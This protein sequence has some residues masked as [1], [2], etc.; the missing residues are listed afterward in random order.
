MSSEFVTL[1]VGDK[2]FPYGTYDNLPVPKLLRCANWSPATDYCKGDVT[3]TCP[4]CLL[5][6]YCTMKCMLADS[7][8][9][10]VQCQ[11]DL[12]KE[13]W[14]A[15]YP[16]Y[17]HSTSDAAP[18]SGSNSDPAVFGPGDT[19]KSPPPSS[20]SSDTETTSG[21]ISD[22]P[23]FGPGDTPKSPPPSSSSSDTDTTSGNISDGDVPTAG[24]ASDAA[25]TSGRNAD[26]AV[27][28]AGSTPSS[29]PPA[30]SASD[31]T[32]ASGSTSGAVPMPRSEKGKFVTRRLWGRTPAVDMLN[33][34]MNEGSDF[35]GDLHLLLEDSAD[36]ASVFLT[37]SELPKTYT[38]SIEFTIN[39]RGDEIVFRNIIMLLLAF[40]VRK[41]EGTVLNKLMDLHAV[42]DCMIHIWYSP[43]LMKSHIDILQNFIKPLFDKVKAKLRIIRTNRPNVTTMVHVWNLKSTSIQATLSIEKWN[44]LFTFI[45]TPAGLTFEK[46]QHHFANPMKCVVTE[47]V[48]NH[49]FCRMPPTCRLALAK[50]YEDGMMLSFG[51]PRQLFTE[52]NPTFWHDADAPFQRGDGDPLDGWNPTEVFNIWSGPAINDIYG[53][54]W[55][56]LGSVLVR[57]FNRVKDLNVTFKVLNSRFEALPWAL[58][59]TKFD[60][61]DTSNIIDRGRRGAQATLGTLS[62]LLQP[63]NKNVHAVLMTRFENAVSA[64]LTPNN[65]KL[66]RP[67][68]SSANYNKLQSFFEG[69]FSKAIRFGDPE[70]IKILVTQRLVC[71]YDA[72]WERYAREE[73]LAQIGHECELQPKKKH[74]I[75]GEWPNAMKLPLG[76]SE[77]EKNLAGIEFHQLVAAGLSPMM[78]CV[79]WQKDENKW[80]PLAMWVL[81]SVL[82]CPRCGSIEHLTWE[83]CLRRGRRRRS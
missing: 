55:I 54:L 16:G 13:T 6:G 60:R 39:N 73:S 35:Q 2:M 4:K 61:I 14:R 19:P 28:A 5:P 33:L 67:P 3:T 81:N 44:K 76:R 52:P 24:G 21:N 25:A 29:P 79:E 62:G 36:L 38:G 42:I 15:T 57:F 46:A 70:T 63:R 82:P 83:C 53:K 30:N 31:A 43:F 56:Y 58:G 20:S 47:H 1:V 22:A 49:R 71:Y 18:I 40:G 51:C 77:T 8:R 41:D 37:I 17:D 68:K 27:L 75:I 64:S 74:T 11:S 78:R 65:T 9:H 23:V 10:R 80:D 50:Y 72:I 48:R 7:A 66:I 26:P 59:D 69:D 12:G 32:P 34:K 45:E